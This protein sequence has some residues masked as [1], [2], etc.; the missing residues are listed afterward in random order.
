MNNTFTNLDWSKGDGL[1]PAIIQDAHTRQVLMLGY[2]SE[3]SLA[4]TQESGKVWFFSRSKQR[5]WM[6]GEQSGHILE[7]KNI[8]HDCDLDSLLITAIPQGSTCH[9]GAVSCF[10][11]DQEKDELS[12]LFQTLRERKVAM[13][14]GSYTASLFEAGLD[15]ICD[16]VSEES[17]EVIRAAKSE[18]RQRLIEEGV[19][20]LYHLFVLMVHQGATREQIDGELKKRRK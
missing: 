9:T 2:M 11:N 6:K 5:L 20:V 18:T 3:E 8:Y 19:D 7:V 13:P 16:K 4:K 17:E 10:Q 14:K 12:T 1:L 15:A